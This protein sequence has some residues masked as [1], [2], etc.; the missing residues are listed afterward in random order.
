MLEMKMDVYH[1]RE[2]S[3]G[4]RRRRGVAGGINCREGE[5]EKCR[6]RE[7]KDRELKQEAEGGPVKEMNMRSEESWAN[8]GNESTIRPV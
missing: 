4:E 6:E 3:E 8:I 7:W 2:L 1:H 5:D